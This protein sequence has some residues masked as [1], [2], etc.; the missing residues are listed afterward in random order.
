MPD[1]TTNKEEVAL[2]HE[3]GHI[4]G[5]DHVPDDDYFMFSVCNGTKISFYEIRIA[6]EK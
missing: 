3:L 2:A 4:L 5:L 1:K 6:R